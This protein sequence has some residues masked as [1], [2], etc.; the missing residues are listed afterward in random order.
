MNKF[1]LSLPRDQETRLNKIEE[2]KNNFNIE[3][4][5]SDNVN[6]VVFN[7]DGSYIFSD[8]LSSRTFKEHPV[9]H[10]RGDRKISKDVTVIL[11][12]W[13]RNKD[14]NGNPVL[15]AETL[16]DIVVEKNLKRKAIKKPESVINITPEVKSDR[17]FLFLYRA[18]RG[19]FSNK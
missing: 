10:V 8:K 11:K 4:E 13:K 19:C 14:S 18:I 7:K 6:F 16:A 12:W 17:G 15:I 2:I 9:F 3:L 5:L 1:A